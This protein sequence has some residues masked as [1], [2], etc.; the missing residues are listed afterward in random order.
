MSDFKDKMMAQLEEYNAATV[1]VGTPVQRKTNVVEYE[2]EA[3]GIDLVVSRVVNGKCTMKMFLYLSQPDAGGRGTMFIKTMKDGTM[4]PA[5]T[6]NIAT[7]LRDLG[8][9]VVRTGCNAVPVLKSGKDFA[10]AI[11][12]IGDPENIELVKEGILNTNMFDYDRYRAPWYVQHAG[13]SRMGVGLG[14][15]HAKLIR[16]M[17][18]FISERTGL[19]YS[20][21]MSDACSIRGWNNPGEKTPTCIWA[22]SALADLFD[23]PYAQRCFEEYYDNRRLAGLDTDAVT[24]LARAVVENDREYIVDWREIVRKFRAGEGIVI[25]DKNRLWEFIQHAVAVGLGRNLRNYIDLYRD[26]LRQAYICDGRVKEKYPDYLQVAHDIYSEKCA[27]IDSFREQE[28]LDRAVGMG[29]P[30]IDQCHH[31]YELRM[32]G[33]VNEF[34]EEAR[35]NCNCVAS[36]VSTVATGKT[37][38]AS[39]RPEG[40]PMTQLTVEISPISGRMVQVKGR[41]NRSPTEKEQKLLKSFQAVILNRIDERKKEENDMT[42]E[43]EAIA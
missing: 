37:W 6:D 36:Y 30:I 25:L 12:T 10:G 14:D 39:F 9:G 34:L 7:F 8:S 31:G 22:F 35:Q 15:R 13:Y 17:V 43:I 29:R 23:E 18:S 41:Y 21:V 42:E 11:R 33:T 3:S 1:Q 26:Y 20:D 19:L 40:S 5:G 2:C 32:L 4:K 38:V 16:H 27:I 24:R 28:G